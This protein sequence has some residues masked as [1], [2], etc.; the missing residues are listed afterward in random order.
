MA[1]LPDSLTASRYICFALL[2]TVMLMAPSLPRAGSMPNV[3]F[4]FV[5]DLRPEL[6][7][8]GH[9]QV[10]APNIERLAQQSLVF[11][12]AYAN[13]PVCGASRGSLLTGL[14]PTADRFVGHAARMDRDTPEAV[15]IFGVLK[16]EGF[17]ALSIGKV[18][19][20]PNDFA[21]FWSEPPRNLSAQRRVQE[22][23]GYRNYQLR[24]NV[25][26]IEEGG[27]G[28]AFESAQVSDDAYFDGQIAD[29]AVRT[30]AEFK[31]QKEPFFLA[32]GL[33][34]PHLPFNAPERYWHLY[35]ESD[36]RL[37]SV[38]TLPLN[39]PRQAWHDWGEL[40][41]YDGIPP[42]PQALPDAL[43]RTLI[44]GYYASVSYIDAL[45]GRILGALDSHGFSDNTIVVLLGDHGWSLGEH[46]LWAKHSTFDVATRTPLI[47]RVP[48]L[49][50]GHTD[51]LVEFID[52]YPTLME[53]LG[54]EVASELHGRSFVEVLQDKSAP[55]KS[56]VFTRWLDAEAIKTPE[57]ALTEW[58]DEQGGVSA[59]MLFDHRT[60]RDETINLADEPAYSDRVEAMHRELMKNIQEREVISVASP[61]PLPKFVQTNL[62]R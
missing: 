27:L 55:G 41:Y 3:L 14:R 33:L 23:M 37:P 39:A 57:F 51:A 28:P 58:F 13:V 30:L 60:D 34:K 15:P 18:A 24:E 47:L 11:R 54:L 7:T 49:D 48:G 62:F 22:R 61:P 17:R 6:P 50:V 42:A 26:A 8:Y 16:A 12:N 40:R 10:H 4:L 29:Q 21:D 20:V 31:E 59:R 2:C 9:T 43:A 45:I 35:Q 5:D 38:N 46:G 53:L 25:Q 52:L 44:H 1:L 19:H 32:V 36:M 56:A